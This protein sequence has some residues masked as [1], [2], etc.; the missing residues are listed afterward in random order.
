MVQIH[1]GEADLEEALI[2]LPPVLIVDSKLKSP[3]IMPLPAKE[4]IVVMSL[5]TKEV[6]NRLPV[7]ENNCNLDWVVVQDNIVEGMKRSIEY[8][9]S[10]ILDARFEDDCGC[11]YKLGGHREWLCSWRFG[12]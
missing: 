8:G 11:L 7:T 10:R 12:I 3:E 6:V 4:A 9:W 1:R 2:T 5:V